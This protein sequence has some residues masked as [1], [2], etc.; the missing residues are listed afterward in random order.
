MNRRLEFTDTVRYRVRT[1]RYPEMTRCATTC[2]SGTMTKNANQT[3]GQG[4][5]S[6]GE[7]LPTSIVWD[8]PDGPA[9]TQPDWNPRNF[10]VPVDEDARIASLL[11][12]SILD[13][14]EDPAFNDLARIAATLCGAP[15]AMI[16]LVDR[17]RQWTK[18]SF[19]MARLTVPRGY[20]ICTQVIA[21]SGDV[22]A[23]TDLAADDRFA[24]HPIVIRS[25]HMRFYAAAPVVTEDGYAL[26]TVCVF[27]SA[28]RTSLEPEHAEALRAVARQIMALIELRRERTA[29][30]EANARLETMVD[31][32]QDVSRRKT[33]IISDVSHEFRTPLTTILGYA[34]LIRDETLEPS[35]IHEFAGDI[36]RDVE[37]LT[38]MMENVLDLERL[39]AGASRINTTTV[40]LGDLIT[41]EVTRWTSDGDTKHQINIVMDPDL[42]TV[43][44]DHD[45]IL[46]VVSNLLGNAVKYSP[47]GGEITISLTAI[48]GAQ[49]FRVEVQDHGIGIGPD[50]H[51]RIFERFARTAEAIRHGIRG[52]GLGLAISRQIIE[53]HGGRIGV[54]SKIGEG[55]RFWFTL[56][57]DRARPIKPKSV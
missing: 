8:P 31:R 45:R 7:A 20:S 56:P 50:S 48:A 6:S 43:S 39:E 35:E 29:L 9:D 33:E 54:D 15:V 19:G 4:R 44:A 34:E 21:Q 18:A 37:R 22:F 27:G 3:A 16:N 23:V 51:R 24:H 32:L 26:G 42:P 40:D 46:Q 28:A 12:Y 41:E 10:P 5:Q 55:S 36:V 25:P 52:T 13:T 47:D 17:E 2:T 38:R 11:G 1:I 53:G 30:N 49:E 57:T 14:P